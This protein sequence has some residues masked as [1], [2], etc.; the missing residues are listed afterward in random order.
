MI[1]KTTWAIAEGYIP[2]GSTDPGDPA[3]VSHETVCILNAADVDA[4]IEITLFFADREPAGPY[5]LTVAARRTRHMR[6][7][8]LSDPEPV[9]RD[10]DYASVIHSTQPVVVQHT[11]LDSRRPEIALMS[12]MAYAHG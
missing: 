7:N 9:P 2:S 10:T 5:R 3:L 1:G 4:D 11:R 12:T 8:D 6:F